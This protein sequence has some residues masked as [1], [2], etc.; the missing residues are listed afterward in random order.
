MRTTKWIAIFLAAL[1][2]SLCIGTAI[3]EDTEPLTQQTLTREGL[4][5]AIPVEAE[6]LGLL[7]YAGMPLVDQP[8]DAV[9][10]VPVRAYFTLQFYF[11]ELMDE[12]KTFTE[13]EL[14]A[15]IRNLYEVRLYDEATLDEAIAAGQTLTRITG[16]A[17]V[18]EMGRQES[19][20]YLFCS[21]DADTANMDEETLAIYQRLQALM[22]QIEASTQMVERYDPA[23]SKGFPPVVAKD[24]A[25][26]TVDNSIFKG[27]KL[28]AINFWGTFCGPC[29]QEMPD[30]GKLGANMPEGT[31]LIGIV[32]DSKGNEALEREITQQAGAMFTQIY[33][34]SSLEAI[35]G[36]LVGVPT[37]MFV[38]ENGNFVGEPMVGSANEAYYR[39][40]I[41]ARLALLP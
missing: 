8:Y 23:T 24:A 2:M 29:I 12:S 36:T 31:Q 11:P 19:L 13:E 4:R 22:P 26:N 5:M 41:A 10:G 34:D 17:N 30:L 39:N 3:S 15:R 25:G 1:I 9:S 33:M 32:T 6:E 7:Q 16:Y 40:E 20:A 35:A 37:T 38:D 14:S 21:P 18:K 27:Y 28:T